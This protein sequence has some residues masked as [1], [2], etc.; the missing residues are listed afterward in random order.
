VRRRRGAPDRPTARPAKVRRGSAEQAQG[1]P[2]SEFRVL[3]DA[4]GQR[5]HHA[6]DGGEERRREDDRGR[7]RWDGAVSAAGHDQPPHTLDQL[8][9]LRAHGI[10]DRM[11]A[12]GELDAQHDH[13]A[14]D[15]APAIDGVA[16]RELDE[17]LGRGKVLVEHGADLGVPRVVHP[18]DGREHQRLLVAELVVERPAGVAGLRGDLLEHEVAVAHPRDPARRGFEQRRAGTGA[19]I[20]LRHAPIA[21]RSGPLTRCH[22]A[23]PRGLG[24]SPGCHER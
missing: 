4:S 11:I 1:H 8:C 3:T 10:A 7:P 24:T 16:A 15:V 13:Q 22:R 14:G 21:R 18:L 19:P 2:L 9:H 5:D 17:R 12:R 23:P 6:L 20:R